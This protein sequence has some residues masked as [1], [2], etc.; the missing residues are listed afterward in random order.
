MKIAVTG[1]GGLVGRFFVEEALAASDEVTNLSRSPARFSAPVAHTPYDLTG[2]A[3]DLSGF[4]AV[5]HCAFLHEP[6]K[7]R[8]GEG[9]DPEGFRH[10]NLGG[11]LALIRAAEAAGVQRFIF[12]SSRAVYGTQ[13]AGVPLTEETKCRPNTL[14]GEV[15]REAEEALGASSL[16]GTSLRATGVY[17]PGPAHKWQGLFNDYRTGKRI[18]P[19]I[20]TEVHGKDLAAAGRIALTQNTP[21]V[22]NVSDLLLDRS[23][24]LTAY[25]EINR[26]KGPIPTRARDRA[27]YNVMDCAA[28][29]ALGWSPGGMA[30][31]KAA[32]K[33]MV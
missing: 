11:T 18:A 28:L 7:Y 5:I 13:P 2:P 16:K 19:R 4:D 20:G 33:E 8:G 30:A 27:A 25:Q 9:K 15:K 26:I 22:L 3:P 14:Y 17:G 31:L 1:G 32:L 24:L 21:P 23:A 12:L 10:A 29:R 6:G